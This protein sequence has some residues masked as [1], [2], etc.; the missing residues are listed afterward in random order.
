MM[1]TKIDSRSTRQSARCER[2]SYQRNMSRK[3]IASS[4]EARARV[5]I[6]RRNDLS[7]VGVVAGQEEEEEGRRSA[8]DDEKN[9]PVKVVIVGG[10]FGGLYCALKLDS[11]QWP[12]NKKPLISLLDANEQ[13]LFK[14]LMYELLENEMDEESVAPR[15]DELL[16]K[17]TVT[18]KKREVVRVVP[19]VVL[20]TKMGTS[21]SGTGGKVLLR[22]RGRA[23]KKNDDDDDGD[24]DVFEK[25]DYLVVALGAKVDFM[26]E[27]NFVNGAKEFAMPFNGL[28]DV[29]KMQ[30]RIELIK[31]NNNNNDGGGKGFE[32]VV[33]V[34]GAGYA[35]VELA[36]C[37]ARWFE[38]EDGLRDVK[39]KLVAKDGEIL[40]N[41]TVGGKNAANKALKKARNIEIVSGVVESIKMVEEVGAAG[42]VAKFDDGKTYKKVNVSLLTGNKDD[43]RKEIIENVDMCCWTVGLSA[44]LPTNEN[45]WPFEQDKLSGKIVTDSTLKVA[46]YDRV[47]A[48]GDNSIQRTKE[49]NEESSNKKNGEKPATAQVAFQAADY[50]AWNVWS[51]INKKSLLPFRYQHL[52]DMMTLGDKEGAVQFPFGAD[53]TLDGQPAFALRRL[54]YLYRMPTNE[55]RLK[56]GQKWF[57][58]IREGLLSGANQS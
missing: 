48:L 11:M 55:Q 35:G 15:F 27:K 50:C 9:K 52:G 20:R 28:E 34:V 53:A 45:D 37:L 51:A 33:T 49:E 18:F 54:A 8:D 57:D 26:S 39:I 56:V 13:F 47:F 10:G 25:Y 32:K 58:E 46:G 2:L 22:N 31:N 14:P 24:D 44:K 21:A 6:R 16:S 17:T 4:E 36:L 12:K 7:D 42:E 40:K 41:A 38:R 29:K 5:L 23:I 43:E 30:E 19:D 1:K 3:R